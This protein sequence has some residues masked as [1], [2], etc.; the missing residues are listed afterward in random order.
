[1]IP[2]SITILT[3][4]L[5]LPAKN[6]KK[7]YFTT[8]YRESVRYDNYQSTFGTLK[9]IFFAAPSVL[10]DNGRHMKSFTIN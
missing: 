1:M 9:G 2:S 7:G 4:E 3:E 10:Q 6:E 8:P 5:T